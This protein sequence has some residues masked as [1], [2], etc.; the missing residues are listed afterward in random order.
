MHALLGVGGCSEKEFQDLHATCIQGGKVIVVRLSGGKE[1]LLAAAYS[2]EGDGGVANLR[3][4][5][6]LDGSFVIKQCTR[7][8]RTRQVVPCLHK[9][10]SPH[11]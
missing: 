2:T 11:A 5:G 6:D 8:A 1:L 9:S 7:D 3:N 10:W 4:A